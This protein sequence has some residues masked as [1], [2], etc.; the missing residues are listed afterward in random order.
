V[1]QIGKTCPSFHSEV[2]AWG[3]SMETGTNKAYL[4]CWRCATTITLPMN[5]GSGSGRMAQLS[6]ANVTGKANVEEHDIANI[7]VSVARD[8]APALHA[9]MWFQRPPSPAPPFSPSPSAVSKR[10]GRMYLPGFG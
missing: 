1:P 9:G 8:K 4:L 6:A 10:D 3:S 5:R 2:W 7:S